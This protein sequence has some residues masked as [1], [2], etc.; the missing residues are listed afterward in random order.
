VTTPI[1]RLRTLGLVHISL[2]CVELAWAFFCVA[3]GAILGAAGFAEDDLGAWMWAGTAVY[4]LLAA[5]STALGLL[6]VASGLAA[7]R[8]RGLVLLVLGAAACLVSM[9]LALYCFPFSLATL[10]YT[11]VVL[12]DA[13]VRRVLDPGAEPG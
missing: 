8:A 4:W 2:G 12:A 5:A 3:G 7:R 6:H 1:E 11:I 10:I 9:V 13:E